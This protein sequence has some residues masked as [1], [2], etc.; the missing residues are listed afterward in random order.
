MHIIQK[1]NFTFLFVLFAICACNNE[2][3]GDEKPALP[4]NAENLPNLTVYPQ[5]QKPEYKI[6]LVAEQSFGELKDIY[7]SHINDIV[8]DDLNR[9]FIAD[10]AYGKC[11]IHV[12]NPD[13]SYVK[14]VGR[15]GKGPGEFIALDK[16]FILDNEL[17]VLDR[18]MQRISVFSLNTFELLETIDI[19]PDSLKQIEDLR[20]ASPSDIY[21]GNDGNFL[22]GFADQLLIQEEDT[23]ENTK[24][25]IFNDDWEIISDQIFSRTPIQFIYS[26]INNRS[27]STTYSFMNQSLMDVTKDGIIFSAWSKDVLIKVHDSNGKYLRSFYHPFNQSKLNKDDIINRFDEAWVN[28]PDGIKR[29]KARTRSL[30]YPE[31]WPAIHNLIVDDENR[32]WIATITDSKTEFEWWLLNDHGE[33]LAKFDWPGEKIDQNVG[34]GPSMEINNGYLYTYEFLD[35]A[36]RVVTRYRIELTPKS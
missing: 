31:T 8:T 29:W 30:D 22:V 19:N 2:T 11:K 35:D 3:T 7:I 10:G 4:E 28:N 18:Q 33:L 24:Y 17:Y 6:E 26:E 16:L 34:S 15:N 12:F 13:G 1:L 27:S 32:I 21:L 36:S 25:Y 20:S 14:T 5:D 9:V 23:R